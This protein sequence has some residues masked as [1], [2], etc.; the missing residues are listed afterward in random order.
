M[1]VLELRDQLNFYL[2]DSNLLQDKFLRHKLSEGTLLPLSLFLSFN[3]VKNALAG[4]PEET[5]K[6][7][8]LRQ[9]V[10]K[11]NM[12]KLSKCG[13]FLKRRIPF[14]PKRVDCAKIDECTVYI[15][16]FPESLTLEG[17][18]K[19]F[20]RAGDIRNITLPKFKGPAPS[21]SGM[22]TDTG[23]QT[24]T[25]GFCFIEF[26]SVAAADHAVATFHNCIPEEFQNAQHKN[27]V[28]VQGQLSQLSVIKKA[29]W[30][31]FKEEVRLIRQEIA[32]LN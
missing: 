1:T 15:E 18:A 4:E 29:T 25:K 7:E 28:N 27:Y 23:S 16:N 14:D 26:D 31:A 6:L 19:I 17:I 9:A 5:A 3:R 13:K 21:E 24:Q 22:E 2:G 10:K 11:S 8:S 30:K 12:L 20:A 32:R